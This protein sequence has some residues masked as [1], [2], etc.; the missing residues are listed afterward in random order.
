MQNTYF[1]LFAQNLFCVN[2]LLC[3]TRIFYN[4]YLI[5]EPIFFSPFTHHFDICAA[6]SLHTHSHHT[7][8]VDS[9]CALLSSSQLFAALR[10]ISQHIILHIIRLNTGG[11]QRSNYGPTLIVSLCLKRNDMEMWKTFARTGFPHSHNTT[12]STI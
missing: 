1:A 11:Y 12:T 2:R 3:G 9:I 5:K 6:F 7:Y 8:E 4:L 10:I